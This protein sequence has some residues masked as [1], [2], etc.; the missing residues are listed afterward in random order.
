MVPAH[1]NLFCSALTCGKQKSAVYELTWC[2]RCFRAYKLLQ[3]IIIIS[4][5]II[6]NKHAKA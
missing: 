5:Q 2:F 4:K 1:V 6:Y 3:I